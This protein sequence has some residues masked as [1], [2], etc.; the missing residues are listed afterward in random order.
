MLAPGGREDLPEQLQADLVGQVQ[1][2][3][4]LLFCY[5]AAAVVAGI[6][7]GPQGWQAQVIP[8]LKLMEE[9]TVVT[10]AAL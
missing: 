5:Q 9:V 7:L 2:K 8:E 4:V 6:T 1:L 3:E 10:V